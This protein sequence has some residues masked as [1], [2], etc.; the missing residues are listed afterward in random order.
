MEIDSRYR[1][2]WLNIA[3]LSLTPLIGVFGT[4]AWTL[5]VGFEWWMLALLVVTYTLVGLSITAGYHRLFSH[6]SYDASP[7]VQLFFALFGAMAAQNSILWW[8]ASHR[9]HHSYVD[10][11]WDPYNIR[12]GFWWAHMVWVFFRNEERDDSVENAKDLLRNPIVMWQHKYNKVILIVGGFGLPALVGWFFGDAIAGLLWG[13]VLRATLVHHSTFFV[14]SLAHT[15]GK[16]TYNFDVSAR[17]NWMVALLTFGEGY[18]SFHHRFAADFRNA[19]K[20]YQWDPSKWLI[21]V[22]SKV[23]LARNLRMTPAPLIEKAKMTA[24]MR[25]LEEQI[26]RAPSQLADEVRE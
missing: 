12:R 15:V 7:V 21:R 13:G 9:I 10:K 5:Y 14:N 17:D 8:S 22:M 3:F 24:S 20:W 1:P 18:H 2:D 26:D 16:P 6:R 4:I 25:K 23:G 19:V 11:D